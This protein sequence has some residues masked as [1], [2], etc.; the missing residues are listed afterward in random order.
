M[1]VNR[2]ELRQGLN[3]VGIDFF[4]LFSRMEFALVAAGYYA[5]D[6]GDFA[7]VAWD[8]FA[9][10]L[11]AGFYPAMQVNPEAEIYFREPPRKLVRTEHDGCV[12]VDAE[13]VT[14]TTSLLLAVRRAR[15]NL[16]HGSKI[17][18]NDRDE[19]LTRA[20]FFVLEAALD[21]AAFGSESCRRVPSI[22]MFSGDLGVR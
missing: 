15:N 4:A 11:P 18:F 12:F 19:A 13:P 9:G 14:D 20:G 1:P 8:S 21:Q 10:E 5:G 7:A 16:F 17:W 3:Q 22:Y 6:V 2:E